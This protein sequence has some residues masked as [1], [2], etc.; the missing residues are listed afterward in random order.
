MRHGEVDVHTDQG[1]EQLPS[2]GRQSQDKF[3]IGFQMFIWNIMIGDGLHCRGTCCVV[4]CGSL[5]GRRQLCEESR[6]LPERCHVEIFSI[7]FTLGTIKEIACYSCTLPVQIQ[8]TGLLPNI[9]YNKDFNDSQIS[10]KVRFLISL[11]V[12][13]EINLPESMPINGSFEIN[14]CNKT[15]PQNP[16]HLYFVILY[17]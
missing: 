6:C 15:K 16:Q 9:V 5:E 17:N 7:M 10:F 12:S 1:H 8:M 13:R 3:N 11:H 4:C 14:G 2:R